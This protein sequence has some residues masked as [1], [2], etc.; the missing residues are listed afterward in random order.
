MSTTQAPPV[1]VWTQNALNVLGDIEPLAIERQK[2]EEAIRAIDEQ[3]AE[4]TRDLV[5]A[6]PGMR[7]DGISSTPTARTV[8]SPAQSGRDPR[9]VRARDK[10]GRNVLRSAK[11]GQLRDLARKLG[12]KHRIITP[13][14]LM[15]AAR[16]QKYEWN[17]TGYNGAKYAIETMVPAEFAI[18]EKGSAGNKTPTKYKWLG[19][20]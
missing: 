10:R 5:G 6:V 7:M 4:L 13:R 20:N 2:H 11:A 8:H 16:A 14:M 18:L 17:E 12:R 1:S 19:L 15:S 9:K 3:M